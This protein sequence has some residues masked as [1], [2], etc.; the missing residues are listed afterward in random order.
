M[1]AIIFSC[2]IFS[3][4]IL[5]LIMPPV[6]AGVDFNVPLNIQA[7]SEIVQLI[8]TTEYLLEGTPPVSTTET[9]YAGSGLNFDIPNNSFFQL[10][11]EGA[12]Y[13]YGGVI[14]LTPDADLISMMPGSAIPSD[15]VTLSMIGLGVANKFLFVGKTDP[16]NEFLNIQHDSSEI[17]GIEFSEGQLFVHLAGIRTLASNVGIDSLELSLL[18]GSLLE[19][20]LVKATLIP[21]AA[22]PASVGANVKQLKFYIDAASAEI[23]D[24][25][26]D[27]MPDAWEVAHSLD[28]NDP[29]DAELNPDNDGLSNLQEFNTGTNPRIAD[30]DGDQI[31]DGTETTNGFDPI[32]A[33]AAVTQ[34]Q[35]LLGGQFAGRSAVA[36]SHDDKFIYG[37]SSTGGLY[38]WNRGNDNQLT[39]IHQHAVQL[40]FNAVTIGQDFVYAS[41]TGA[42]YVYDR[43]PQT[44]LLSN[45]FELTGL[46][47]GSDVKEIL[48]T[49]DEK[50]LYV[51]QSN[52]LHTY[53]WNNGQL[54]KTG[55]IGT[56]AFGRSQST[57]TIPVLELNA[58]ET[59]LYYIGRSRSVAGS[60]TRSISNGYLSTPV[61]GYKYNAY[62]I[63]VRNSNNQIYTLDGRSGTFD[64]YL[65]VYDA[66]SSLLSAAKHTQ[67]LRIANMEIS[68]DSEWLYVQDY[69]TLSIYAFSKTSGSAI[70]SGAI[71]T[72]GRGVEV[73]H[74]GQYLYIPTTTGLKVLSH[75]VNFIRDRDS[76]GVSD[77]EDAFPD[78]CQRTTNSDEDSAADFIFNITSIDDLKTTCEYILDETSGEPTT[79]IEDVFPLDSSEWADNDIDGIGDN[80]DLDDDNDQMPDLWEEQ[81][82]GLLPKE[83]DADLDLDS[84]NASNLTEFKFQTDPTKAHS[85]DDGIPDGEEIL[86]GTNPNNSDTDGD[87]S[88]DS[89]DHFA[90]DCRRTT[91]TDGDGW[92]DFIYVENSFVNS[93]KL[94]CD[95]S[96][97]AD[98]KERA[99]EDAF[100]NDFREWSAIS[101]NDVV[102]PSNQSN[103]DDNSGILDWW[104]NK[105]P[106]LNPDDDA[107]TD[108]LTNIEEFYAGTNPNLDDTD[109]DGILDGADEYPN[110][111]EG[112]AVAVIPSV[113]SYADTDSLDVDLL[114]AWVAL[115]CGT[116]YLESW[117]DDEEKGEQKKTYKETLA[118]LN[119]PI[120]DTIQDSDIPTQVGVSANLYPIPGNDNGLALWQ[121]R[122]EN[123]PA[124]LSELSQNLPALAIKNLR[125]QY[126]V[127]DGGSRKIETR[128]R[129]LI[130]CDNGSSWINGD[131]DGDELANTPK[132]FLIFAVD[133][134]IALNNKIVAS[135]EIEFVD[136]QISD[137][138]LGLA[139]AFNAIE[140]AAIIEGNQHLLDGLR[141]RFVSKQSTKVKFPQE[142]FNLS[143]SVLASVL[144]NT[145]SV[146]KEDLSIVD[147]RKLR[148]KASGDLFGDGFEFMIQNHNGDTVP[149]DLFRH[150]D[151]LVKYG[152][153]AN[154]E[155]KNLYYKDN[156]KDVDNP[157]KGN[158][159]GSED[160]DID[161]DGEINSA[162]RDVAAGKAKRLGN[163]LFYS[164]LLLN[165]T[166]DRESYNQNA[167]YQLKRQ[168]TEAN[169]LYRDIKS[170][171]N[172]LLLAGD[173]VPYQP[174]EHFLSL[175]SDLVQRAKEAEMNA[176]QR[177]DEFEVN[178]TRLADE[179]QAQKEQYL[180]QIEALTGENIN[181]L[182]LSKF[183]KRQA[184]VEAVQNRV[185]PKG[186]LG[187]QQLAIQEAQYSALQISQQIQDLY[188]RV[189]IEERRNQRTTNLIFADGRK[190][191]VLDAA[192]AASQCC[193]VTIAGI[194]SGTSVDIGAFAR[195]GIAQAQTW[196]R[197]TQQAEL[198]DINS[199][200]AIKNIL[201][202]QARLNLAFAQATVSI[203]RLQVIENNL[204]AQLERLLANYARSNEKLASAY[205]NDPSF[206]L[207]ATRTEQYAND[208]FESAMEASYYAGKALEYQWSEKFNNPVLKLDGGLSSPLS[209]IYDPFN[210][211]ES[212][213]GSQFAAG[214]SPSLE[215][216]LGSL[217]AWDVR[218][219]QL[220]Y[221]T[222]QSATT[223][224]SMRNDILGYG[225]Y[226]PEVAESLFQTFIAENRKKGEN[227]NNDDLQFNFNMDIV[228]E[229]LFPNLPNIK[230]ESISVNLVSDASRSIRTSPRTDAPLVDM[231]MLDRA[232]VRTFFA[233]Y[234]SQ[235]D[236]LTYELQEGRT[237]DK[238]PFLA[239][240]SA[241]V[242]GYASPQPIP[243]VQLANHSPAA[244]IWVMRMKNNRF[245][246]R[247]LAL[248][249]LSDIEVDITYS[250]GKP[251]AIQFPY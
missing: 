29:L 232:F 238:S 42:V 154:N 92:A 77:A 73:S 139:E 239:S 85:D 150:T 102:I 103:D 39:Q 193:T 46:V 186:E 76:D 126:I 17:I 105:Y 5:S 134:F 235:D 182:D 184:Y 183:E 122:I 209:V 101:V 91:D 245:N 141:A 224:F 99:I 57:S 41:T 82:V 233:D 60:Y 129:Y 108:G 13:S 83:N 237:I 203:E 26:N 55:Q 219:R 19:S 148:T 51:A 10:R 28:I 59:Q 242:D 229:R 152:I 138:K 49:S 71:N 159:P 190:M 81:Y 21:D 24:S 163:Q 6:Q 62:E 52:Y 248:E 43:D 95:Y 164:G 106:N 79:S 111:K 86:A 175:A 72:D 54:E 48:A 58:D 136:G 157:P 142:Y 223:R 188:K 135:D 35:E 206:R 180:D 177:S 172:P 216:Y 69:R 143:T 120:G 171:Y 217:K 78:D 127:I 53:Y 84:D 93:N 31:I 118:H 153:S 128:N 195:G 205:F 9:K 168:V 221:P 196:L 202:D 125:A 27:G 124:L 70:F 231:V 173:F 98:T 64:Y 113:E 240:V 12:G 16:N 207:Q 68:P 3:G 189:E 18:F 66:G 87:G 214:L 156:V 174:V 166:Q 213:F 208:A 56:Y 15:T 161:G 75:P 8:G 228:T 149:A 227:P 204:W 249:Y 243:N 155:A 50:N 187:S 170:G 117:V 112:E 65:N 222:K 194:A 88:S 236:I 40:N 169:T 7:E 200:S 2:I 94:S 74:D 178:Q 89:E 20:T 167:G 37:A 165:A 11:F 1:K 110:Y 244:S 218:M 225:I 226:A 210:R 234:P 147:N 176:E 25:D 23:V 247:D 104:E 160:L 131:L 32:V 140:T 137:A 199:D 191:G 179:L 241:S 250:Y 30:T 192:Y 22:L 4:V 145:T 96:M 230:I 33:D 130:R 181:D 121:D 132:D 97:V 115:E 38:I 47:V 63:A 107:D 123:K 158:F 201:V 44:G 80:A 116:S 215:D 162:G 133:K 251:R 144:S 220:R 151:L 61:G 212:V 185:E 109:K 197:A 34:S 100:I 246:N 45:G 67:K 119:I 90:N 198:D 211:A 14:V 114:E 146:I 36:V